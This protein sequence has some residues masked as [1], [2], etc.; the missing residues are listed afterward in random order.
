MPKFFKL[1]KNDYNWLI[2]IDIGP[3]SINLG[4]NR[5]WTL[6]TVQLPSTVNNFRPHLLEHHNTLFT[7]FSKNELK[8]EITS[9]LLYDY[10]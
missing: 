2:H 6:L 3:T 10:H 1:F 4:E 7:A 5:F 8:I 9:D